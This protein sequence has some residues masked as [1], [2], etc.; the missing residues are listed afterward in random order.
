MET[1]TNL[2]SLGTVL[3]AIK[4]KYNAPDFVK[5]ASMKDITPPA[6]SDNF[7]EILAD[8]IRLQYPCHTKAAT[9]VS[10]AC[11]ADNQDKFPEPQRELIGMNIEKFAKFHGILPEVEAIISQRNRR[12]KQ[13]SM[14]EVV[15]DDQYAILQEVNGKQI[16]A[17]L[18]RNPSELKKAAA[19][20]IENRN[21]MPLENCTDIASRII[22]RAEALN[23]SLEE[24]RRLEQLTGKG[25]R[26]SSDIAQCL[27]ERASIV[28][29]RNKEASVKMHQ[30]ATIFEQKPYRAGSMEMYKTACAIDKFDQSCGLTAMRTRGEIPFPEEVCYEVTSSDFRKFAS[31]NVRLQTGDIYALENV[32][33]VPRI[34]F[35]ARLGKDL[36]D[37]CY[38][39][40]HF[41]K[42]AALNILPTLPRPM[43]EDVVKLLRSQGIKPIATEKASSAIK[44]PYRYFE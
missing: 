29:P 23:V 42:E 30:L 40:L 14:K 39:G 27:H 11:F 1:S 18:M 25:I 41:D 28:A 31:E 12:I 13:A 24:N 20:L 22:K 38:Q 36:T 8:P 19:W 35:E 4:Q 6:D 16:K 44:I 7:Y 37:E 9:W 15:P 10:A 26:P 5:S 43:A 21:E 33:R 32:S 3:H 34:D 2:D 17:G